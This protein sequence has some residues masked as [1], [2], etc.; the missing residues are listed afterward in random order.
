MK[1]IGILGGTFNPIHTGHLLLAE[2]VKEALQL[3]SVI[4]IPCNFPPHKKCCNLVS[5]KHRLAMVKSAIKDCKGFKVSTIEA[6]RGGR[7]YS[8]DTLGKLSKLYKEKAEFFFIIGSDSIIGLDDWKEIKKLTKMCKMVA[9]A[10]PGYD[11]KYKGVKVLKVPTFAVS[12]TNI[13]NLVKKRKSIKYLVPETVRK[14]IVKHRLF[15]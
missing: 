9:V 13:R 8:V 4:F 15:S 6:E 14:Y 10:R 1:R 3:D 5:V 12:S 7:S 11:L 2:G